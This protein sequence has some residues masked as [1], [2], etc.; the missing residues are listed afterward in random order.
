[1]REGWKKGRGCIAFYPSEGY[2]S[3]FCTQTHS[4]RCVSCLR[5]IDASAGE[6]N[7]YPLNIVR[8]SQVQSAVSGS[9]GDGNFKPFT[10]AFVLAG[11]QASEK[12]FRLQLRLL[13]SGQWGRLTS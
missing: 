5:V 8:C 7:A 2:V 1:M 3:Y 9:R 13:G 6:E 10:F 11:P 12:G 4:G